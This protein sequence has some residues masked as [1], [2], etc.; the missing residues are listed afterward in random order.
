MVPLLMQQPDV[1]CK[2][3]T[4]VYRRAQLEATARFAGELQ[5]PG[6]GPFFGAKTHFAKK[7]L[8]ENMDLSPL[9]RDLTICRRTAAHHALGLPGKVRL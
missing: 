9:R 4:E 7:W 3:P 1:D 5:S 2:I 6:T 8:A